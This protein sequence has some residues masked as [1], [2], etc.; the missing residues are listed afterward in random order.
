MASSEIQTR[1]SFMGSGG[2]GFSLFRFFLPSGTGTPRMRSW[3]YRER[4]LLRR[5]ASRSMIRRVLSGRW[6]VIPHLRVDSVFAIP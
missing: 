4:L 5:S 3:I 1:I 2:V 6:S